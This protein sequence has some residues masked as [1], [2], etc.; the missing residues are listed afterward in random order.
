M[1]HWANTV[2]HGIIYGSQ[3]DTCFKHK[4]HT[5]NSECQIYIYIGLRNY[6]IC[7]LI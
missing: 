3:T 6:M 2:M 7:N 1:S 5:N 4:Y